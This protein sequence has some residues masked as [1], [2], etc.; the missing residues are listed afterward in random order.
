MI[1]VAKVTFLIKLLP[2]SEIY[3]FRAVSTAKKA[4]LLISAEV[5][6]TPSVVPAVSVVPANFEIIP[7][8]LTA[9]TW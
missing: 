3:K 2:E 4:G 8:L 9:R 7:V 6:A 1:P 5:A